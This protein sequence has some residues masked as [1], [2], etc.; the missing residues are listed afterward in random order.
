MTT[1]WSICL[2]SLRYFYS[3]PY[4][5]RQDTLMGHDDAVSDMCWFDERLYTASWDSTVKVKKLLY[6][7]DAVYK[8]MDLS[9]IQ[10]DWESGKNGSNT[11]WQQCAWI[12]FVLCLC[13]RE[14]WPLL[15]VSQVWKCPYDSSSN[16]KRSQFEVLAELEHDAGVSVDAYT[17]FWSTS[18]LLIIDVIHK[19]EL[20]RVG[21]KVQTL[22]GRSTALKTCTCVSLQ[23][24]TI[25]LNPAG[26]LLVSGC[27]DGAVSL[28]DTSSYTPLQQV[29]CHT[30]TIHHTA[31]SPGGCYSSPLIFT[32]DKRFFVAFFRHAILWLFCH[33]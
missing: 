24:N 6:W 1:H 21:I 2:S 17:A 9:G 32:R 33:F 11:T 13:L 18:L 8:A 20:K 31:F 25:G 28:W 16:H 14:G 29:H 26:T 27:K 30:G 23:V 10:K 22:K 7:G 12:H 3:I 19:E 15:F 4:G 5:R